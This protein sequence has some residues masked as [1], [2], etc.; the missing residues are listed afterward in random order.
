[1]TEDQIVAA[2]AAAATAIVA[3]LLAGKAIKKLL[4]W[5]L[6]WLTKKTKTKVDDKI[7][8]QAQIDVGINPYAEEV[9]DATPPKE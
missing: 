5:P 1:M 8:E 7:V 3:Q 9:K 2:V 6:E 4:L